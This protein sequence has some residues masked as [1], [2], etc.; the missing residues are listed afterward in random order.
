MSKLAVLATCSPQAVLPLVDSNIAGKYR[1]L[2]GRIYEVEPVRSQ[3]HGGRHTHIILLIVI[4][5]YAWSLYVIIKCMS[6]NSSLEVSFQ[7]GRHCRVKT[8]LQSL[9]NLNGSLIIDEKGLVRPTYIVRSCHNYRTSISHRLPGATKSKF[10]AITII[11]ETERG[12]EI[13]HHLFYM[14]V[15]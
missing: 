15:Q 3:K 6:H 14:L 4:K 10:Q 11:C 12:N 1:L 7:N 8:K 2:I 5:Y 13:V 9:K